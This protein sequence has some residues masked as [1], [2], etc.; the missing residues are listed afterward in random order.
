MTS[1]IEELDGALV[2]LLGK[3]A[4]LLSKAAGSRKQKK[5]SL[6]DPVQEKQ[7]WLNWRALAEK[8][9][10]D[11]RMMHTLFHLANG[12]GYEQIEHKKDWE[13]ELRPSREPVRMD[14]DGPKDIL[15]TRMW[16]FLGAATGMPLQLFA[17]VLNDSLFELIKGLNQAGGSFSWEKERVLCQKSP[18]P[19]F[20]KKTIFVGQDPLNLYLLI[21]LAAMKPGVC[22]FSGGSRLKLTDLRPLEKIVRDLGGRM[23]S[24]VP[25]SH[26]LPVRLESAGR[27][28]KTV[29]LPAA[30]SQE[31]VQALV[32]ALATVLT[33]ED[34]VFLVPET[35]EPLLFDL[36]RVLAALKPWG[37][38][39]EQLKTSWVIRGGPLDLPGF[40]EVPLDPQFCGYLLGLAAVSRGKVRLQG[41]FPHDLPESGL[42]VDLCAKL[43]LDLKIDSRAILGEWARGQEEPL[44]V[45]LKNHSWCLPLVLAQAFCRLTETEI[46]VFPGQDLDF[47]LTLLDRLEVAYRLQADLLLIHTGLNLDNFPELKI[48]AVHG[49]WG[50]ALAVLALKRPRLVVTNPGELTRLWPQ[51]WSLFKGLPDPQRVRESKSPNPQGSERKKTRR[52]ID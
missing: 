38:R 11:E 35:D 40:P 34:E 44:R 26:G 31:M 41:E 10:L 4:R 5:K 16:V 42:V 6:V 19:D 8:Q 51:F 23:I 15:L 17:V 22:R 12:L 3:R 13:L 7:L 1:E 2:R 20:D 46:R 33:P 27:I 32:L 50:M 28:E 25:G 30:V 36:S 37:G 21:F 9:G 39:F 29:H 24:L 14:L 49:W 18:G 48:R 43:G 52:K 47:A 45:D